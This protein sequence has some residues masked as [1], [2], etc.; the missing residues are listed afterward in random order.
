MEHYGFETERFTRKGREIIDLAVTLAGRWGHTYVGTEHILLACAECESSAAGTALLKY[1]VTSEKICSEIQ[2][3]IGRGTPCLPTR[4]DFTPN[5]ESA[6]S[7]AIRLCESFGG[8]VAGSEYILAVM[9]RIGNCC[10]VTILRSLG[11]NIN[12]LYGECT[13][14]SGGKPGDKS[15]MPDIY[16][17]RSKPKL[18]T[19]ERY[20]RELTD[21]K[22]CAEFDPLVGREDEINRIME[23]LCRRGKNNPCLVGEAGV[24]KTAVVEGLAAKI[25]L[26]DVSDIL[27]GK[28][29]FALD[30]TMLLAGAKYRGDF[31]ERLKACIDEAV[32]AGN[33]ILFID[34]LHNIMGAG[35][36]EGAID[37][38]NILKPQLARRGL[39]VIGATT[40][41]EYRKNI[42]KDS[43]MD[44]RFQKVII[45][46]PD[47]E[48][49]A[50]ILLG[51]RERY[52]EHH[53][54]SISEEMCRYA[55]KLAGR[56][57]FERNFPDKAIDVLDEACSAARIASSHKESPQ[58][59][60]SAFN[61]YLSGDISRDEYLSSLSKGGGRIALEREHI[62][63]VVSRATGI[64]CTALDVEESRRLANLEQELSSEIIGQQEAVRSLCT[65]VR[66]CRAGLKNHKRPV[67]SFV[68]LGSTGVGKT[69]LAKSLGKALFGSED[70]VIKL[71][72][73][74]YMERHSLSKLIGA[75]PGYV[76]FDEG[77][78]LTERVRKKPY[79]VVLLDE[80]EKAHPDVYN[81]LLQ[82]LEDGVLTNSSG[83]RV[84]FANTI[85]IMTSNAGAKTA[86]EKKYVGF[87][88][89]AQSSEE[90]EK[91]LKAELK[92]IMSPELLGRIDEIIVFKELSE[93]SLE[94]IAQ[95]ELLLL[96][97]RLAEI[98][99]TLEISE[100]CG[101]AIAQKAVKK[102]GS[103]R[104]VRRFVSVEIEN[105]ISDKILE[106]GSKELML[107]VKDGEPEVRQTAEMK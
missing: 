58:R 4:N 86:A 97:G 9:L 39:Q 59:S 80:I 95:R 50:Q 6:L 76:G 72:M 51:L 65:A 55:V 46:E 105:L 73:S 62:E 100:E 63:S 5:A 21:K 33:C 78:Q 10:C 56:Y 40:F 81:I 84:S 96:C 52:E 101:T 16:A 103:A 66:R 1:G 79:S 68:F 17:D 99:Y 77:G 42:E 3:I 71:D 20:G 49:T 88:E 27:A 93:E 15:A 14:V 60:N 38:A 19:L 12:R 43:A 45:E 89:R 85:V 44:R 92:N 8:N 70:S 102:G 25:M 34:E 64:D 13:A 53:K 106:G 57:I 83:R 61:R 35:A 98:G 32:S 104:E 90:K 24:G 87:S 107:C 7:G 48:R 91:S 75:P 74:E 36:A 82:I 11:V 94:K 28:R 69:Q 26:G 54:I 47:E 22:S 29:I 30:L 37:A 23:I 2:R 18:K 31:E 41:E 67:G